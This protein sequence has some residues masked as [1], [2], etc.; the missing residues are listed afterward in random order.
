MSRTLSDHLFARVVACLE[1]MRD[2]FPADD[3]AEPDNTVDLDTVN[4]ESVDLLREFEASPR[5]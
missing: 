4:A 5:A 3:T 1:F 2:Y